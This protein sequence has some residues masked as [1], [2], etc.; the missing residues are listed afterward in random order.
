MSHGYTYI[1]TIVIIIIIIIIIIIV[2]VILNTLSWKL[3]VEDVKIF[4]KNLWIL[5]S[6]RMDVSVQLNFENVSD[7]VHGHNKNPAGRLAKIH[8]VFTRIINTIGYLVMQEI[9]KVTKS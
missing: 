1:A 2:I 5:A 8:K 4:V 6:L 9:R 7:D 3:L